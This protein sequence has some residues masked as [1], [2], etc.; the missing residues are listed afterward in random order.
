MSPKTFEQVLRENKAA[1][2]YANRQEAFHTL[3]TTIAKLDKLSTQENVGFPRFSRLEKELEIN[4]SRLRELNGILVRALL[5]SEPSLMGDAGMKKDSDAVES[6][7]DTSLDKLDTMR[8]RSEIQQ[9]LQGSKPVPDGTENLTEILKYMQDENAKQSKQMSDLISNLSKN[10]SDNI[11]SLMTKQDENMGKLVKNNSSAA[12]KPVQPMFKSR[13]N[14]T[15]YEN[16]RDFLPRFEH[17]VNRVA[18][19]KHKLEWLKSSISGDAFSLIKN[20][21]LVDSNYKIALNKLA[22][23][24]LNNEYIKEKLI[25]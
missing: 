19:D 6:A 9:A 5:A 10:Q 22:D 24:Y 7:I 8:Q 20:L 13:E 11:T 21:D 1:S 23:K 25:G 16:Y 17:F 14:D 2:A 12:P 4:I 15:D 3:G 18:T